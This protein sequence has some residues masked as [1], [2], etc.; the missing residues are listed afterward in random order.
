MSKKGPLD[1][2]CACPCHDNSSIMH[3]VPCCHFTYQPR[4]RASA[5]AARLQKLYTD[6]LSL[7][8]RGARNS[9]GRTKE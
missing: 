5:A 1:G 8:P 3:F 6:V 9:S 2:P 7:T 4:A